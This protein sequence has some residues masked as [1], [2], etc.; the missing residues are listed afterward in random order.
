LDSLYR[1]KYVLYRIYVL[2]LQHSIL[3]QVVQQHFAMILFSFSLNMGSTP[4]R[5]LS[6]TDLFKTSVIVWPDLKVG[7]G[8]QLRPTRWPLQF[9]I[10]FNQNICCFLTFQ[11]CI[12]LKILPTVLELNFWADKF[13]FSLDRIWTPTIDTLQHHSLNIMPSALINQATSYFLFYFCLCF[14]TT[15]SY[16]SAISWWPVLVVEEAGVPGENH[17]PWTSN[18]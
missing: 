12:R 14:N 10:Y 3:M 6:I 16:I 11:I 13:V 4:L 18:W 8:P 1:I 5:T 15:F 17:R 2:I 9:C 7:I